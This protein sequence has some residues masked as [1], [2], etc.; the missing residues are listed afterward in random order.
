MTSGVKHCAVI[1]G[2]VFSSRCPISVPWVFFSLVEKIPSGPK[3]GQKLP[4]ERVQKGPLFFTRHEIT[5]IEK[6]FQTLIKETVIIL[7]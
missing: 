2:S 3:N 7:E 4:S 1:F 5:I 6:I